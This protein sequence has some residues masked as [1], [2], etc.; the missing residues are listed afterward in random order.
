M[1]ITSVPPDQAA[2]TARAVTWLSTVLDDPNMNKNTFPPELKMYLYVDG[3]L[4]QVLGGT[5]QINADTIYLPNA[6]RAV[7]PLTKLGV[8]AAIASAT[9]ASQ[10]PVI[11]AK[12]TTRLVA[13]LNEATVN[14]YGSI[15]TS[16][17]RP[18]RLAID[19]EN[20]QVAAEI[21]ERWLLT[22]GAPAEVTDKWITMDF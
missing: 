9:K 14:V 21:N 10:D 7:E 8:L 4:R 18:T 6:S 19:H 13:L 3:T 17:Q 2:L 5:W 11:L 20:L 1:Q 12:I 16:M 22:S 15:I